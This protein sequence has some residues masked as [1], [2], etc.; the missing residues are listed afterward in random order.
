MFKVHHAVIGIN[1]MDHKLIYRHDSFQG[2]VGVAK[3]DITPQAGIY[4]R[5]WGAASHDVADG[6]DH[7]LRA[8]VMTLQSEPDDLPMVLVT[9]DLGWWKSAK[10]EW[11]IRGAIMDRFQL[12]PEQVILSLTHTHSGPGITSDDKEK[13]G[14][15]LI[16]AYLDQ[17]RDAVLI[18]ISRALDTKVLSTV[19]WEYGKCSLARN[20][21]LTDPESDRIVCGFNPEITADDTL[22]VGR[23][24]DWDGKV[25]LT[26]ANYACHPTSLAWQ[27]HLI[28]PDWVGAFYQTVES[29]IGGHAMFL[30]GASGELQPARTYTADLE[31]I[32]AQGRQLAYATLSVLEGMLPAGTQLEYDAVVE[33]GAPLACWKTTSAEASNK[34]EIQFLELDLPLKVD[35]PSQADLKQQIADCT[36]RVLTER[37]TRKLHIRRKVGEGKTVKVPVYL[38]KMGDCVIV[39][40]PNESYSMLQTALRTHFKPHSVVVINLANGAA[41]GYLPPQD[42]YEKDIYQVW[43]TPFAAGSLEQLISA[44]TKKVRDVWEW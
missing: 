22:L 12:P 31:I 1:N 23:V 13:P 18:A 4:S 29:V 40:S 41:S 44:I 24:C 20:R 16:S 39:A 7:P 5:N 38:W 10:D 6:V 8:M 32:R 14:G 3:E 37:L 17:V 19:T 25:L 42:L 11:H 30:Q 43:Q 33:S 15:E 21:D 35:L 26:I 28:S 34:T 36:D 9:L 27:N 2:Y